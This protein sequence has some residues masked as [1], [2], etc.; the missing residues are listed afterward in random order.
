MP[1]PAGDLGRRLALAELEYL[2]RGRAALALLLGDE[3]GLAAVSMPTQEAIVPKPANREPRAHEAAAPVLGLH[4]P[5]TLE[6]IDRLPDRPASH[7]V[8]LDQL[9]LAR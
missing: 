8:P 2:D 7:A 3:R 6:Q 9:L 5:L 4:Q 1:Q